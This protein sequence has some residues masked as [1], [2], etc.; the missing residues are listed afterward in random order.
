MGS[1]TSSYGIH[2]VDSQ[3]ALWPGRLEKSG[4]HKKSEYL[5]KTDS[6]DL[7]VVFQRLR[8]FIRSAFFKIYSSTNGSVVGVVIYTL[9]VAG[10][11]CL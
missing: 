2:V 10:H 6:L 8:N 7:N 4:P 11:L 5:V 3:T 1:A 9:S